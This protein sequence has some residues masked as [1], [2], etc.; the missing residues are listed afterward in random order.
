MSPSRVHIFGCALALLIGVGA[1]FAD[2]STKA[3]TAKGIDFFES[4]VRPV[5]AL[6]CYK[7]HS[8]SAGKSESG[9]MLDSREKIRAG[10]DRGPAVVPDDPKASILLTAISH[11]DPDL[12]M[13]PKKDRLPDSVIADIRSWIEMGAPDP[14]GGDVATTARPPVDI[15]AGRRF[16]SLQKPVAY[17]PPTTKNPTWALRDLD[18]FV[19]AKLEAA[20]LAPSADADARTL[21][22]RVT[23][24]LTGLPPSPEEV[25]QFVRDYHSPPTT[26]HSH[27]AAYEVYIDQLLASPAF[28]ERWGRHWLDVARF[29]ESSGKEANI[30]FP[31]AW[32]YRDYVIDAVNDDVPFD[33]FVT[34]Q[35]AGDLLPYETAA[36]RARLLIATGFL[37]IGPKNLDEGNQLQFA[38][39]LIDEQIDAVTRAVMASSVACA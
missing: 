15:E 7:C 27:D 22:R 20:G 12:K 3:E 16:W 30:S 10:G 1:A 26:H 34:E 35:I 14:R 2:E 33:R 31:D 8:T 25:N 36:E 11:T 23:F 24:D 29:A 18:Q 17:K 21:I 39:D 32:R 4:K 13:P 9:L 5:L 19:L 38:A 6:H 37:A 28:G